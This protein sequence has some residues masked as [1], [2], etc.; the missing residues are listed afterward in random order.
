[1]KT[2]ETLQQIKKMI[3]QQVDSWTKIT[4]RTIIR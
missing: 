3:T 4:S 2:F 1:M